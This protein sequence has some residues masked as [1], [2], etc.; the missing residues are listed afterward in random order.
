LP[1]ISI[2]GASHVVRADQFR[3]QVPPNLQQLLLELLLRRFKPT[4]LVVLAHALSI[5]EPLTIAT[6][7]SSVGV[8][9]I[10]GCGVSRTTQSFVMPR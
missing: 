10:V 6:R 7:S 4:R 9:R 1:S 3:R 2:T 8:A 5:D